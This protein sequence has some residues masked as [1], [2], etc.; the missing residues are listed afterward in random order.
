MRPKILLTILLVV[1]GLTAQAQQIKIIEQPNAAYTDTRM[2]EISKVTLSDTATILDMKAFSTPTN[3]IKIVSDTYLLA[4]GKKYMIRSSEVIELDLLFW[5]PQSG[6]IRFKLIFDPLPIETTTFD[7]IGS[8]SDDYYTIYGVD[9]MEE[10]KGNKDNEEIKEGKHDQLFQNLIKPFEGKV[11]LVDI[12]ATWCG[13][14]MVANLIMQPI[15]VEFAEKDVVFLYIA[16]ENSPEIAW[17]NM[18]ADMQG[19]HHRLSAEQWDYLCDS[20]N[21]R[22]VPTYIIIDREGNQS[23]HTV[24]FPGVSKI[25]R[26][27]NQALNQ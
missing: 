15:K 19:V 17:E 18:I 5:M 10:S 23:Y 2:L 16:G 13:P 8:D 11:I 21:V 4:D 7:F 14:C 1:I 22:G 9:L 27:L 6:E 20:L 3:S 24:G 26:E 25:R 12:W